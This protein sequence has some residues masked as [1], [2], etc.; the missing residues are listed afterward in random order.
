MKEFRMTARF[1]DGYKIRLAKNEKEKEG[2]SVVYL[3]N[4]KDKLHTNEYWELYMRRDW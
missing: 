2:Y 3:K 1:E 4:N